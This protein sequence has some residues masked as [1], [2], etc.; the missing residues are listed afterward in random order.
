MSATRPSSAP[1]TARERALGELDRD[2][3]LRGR[4]GV[5][6][7]Q[8]E[9]QEA[10]RV[11][12]D[13]DEQD[14][15]GAQPGAHGGAQGAALAQP[16]ELVEAPRVARRVEQRAGRLE[17]RPDRAARERLEADGALG[18]EVDDGLEADVDRPVGEHV[19]DRLARATRRSGMRGGGRHES[20]RHRTGVVII[21]RHLEH[22]PRGFD[23]HE[24]RPVRGPRPRPPRRHQPPREAQRPQ[25]RGDRARCTRRSPTPRPIAT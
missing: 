13:V 25:R 2:D 19:A 7:A 18:H 4:L 16:V 22:R 6:G 11:G 14:R 21:R 20:G 8:V 24:H 12:L 5:Q 15:R 1:G 23:T 9:R 3:H 17:L 10:R